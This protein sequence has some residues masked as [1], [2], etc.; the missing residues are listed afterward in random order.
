VF[1]AY[2]L[3]GI[4]VVRTQLGQ[5]L[6]LKNNGFNLGDRKKNVNLA[7]HRYLTKS[8]GK[9]P[10]LISQPWIKGMVQ[11]TVLNVVK[12]LDFGRHQEVNAYVKIL[13][14]CYHGGY[15][16]LDKRITMDPMLIHQITGL[17]VKGPDPQQFYL[18]KESNRSLAQRIKEAYGEVEKGK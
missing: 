8:T 12:I 9:N 7:P 1:T 5:I 3:K 15:L 17:S 10:H 13:P 2:I 16:W 4:R 18:G 14:S 6:L 11:S